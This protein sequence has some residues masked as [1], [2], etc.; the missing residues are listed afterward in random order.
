[1]RISCFD[2]TAQPNA[3]FMCDL[4]TLH[5]YLHVYTRGRQSSPLLPISSLGIIR[6]AQGEPGGASR[7]QSYFPALNIVFIRQPRRHIETFAAPATP[8][9]VQTGFGGLVFDFL[10]DCCQNCTEMYYSRSSHNPY[11]SVTDFGYGLIE[12][13]GFQDGTKMT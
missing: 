9:R 4:C 2:T 8:S 1:M 5:L 3:P 13:M 11:P 6:Q 10:T 12:S 7:R